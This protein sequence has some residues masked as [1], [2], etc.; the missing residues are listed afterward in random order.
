M[1][2]DIALSKAVS[3]PQEVQP[4][5]QGV[6][7]TLQAHAA[8]IM[9]KPDLV[10]LPIKMID[11]VT[12]I[13]RCTADAVDK[14]YRRAGRIIRLSEIDSH[15]VTAK[16]I[17]GSPQASSAR[18]RREASVLEGDDFTERQVQGATELFVFLRNREPGPGRQPMLCDELEGE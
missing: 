1:S 17:E 5:G 4:R 6:R 9:E 16:K 3:F 11:K 7:D 14:Q 18:I 2:Y 15:S 10:P 13:L 12:K 8:R